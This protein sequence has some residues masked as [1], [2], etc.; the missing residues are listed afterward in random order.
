[1]V[2]KK[3]SL[4]GIFF[5]LIF[6]M[7]INFNI[8]FSD[9]VRP[10]ETLPVTAYTYFLTDEFTDCGPQ[11]SKVIKYCDEYYFRKKVVIQGGRIIIDVQDEVCGKDNRCEE[12]KPCSINNPND[13][14][15]WQTKSLS[16]GWYCPKG[17]ALAKMHKPGV[18]DPNFKTVSISKMPPYYEKDFVD[19]YFNAYIPA[20]VNRIPMLRFKAELIKSEKVKKNIT[21]KA[22]SKYGF[23]DKTITKEFIENKVKSEK[24]GLYAKHETLSYD[25]N[26][27]GGLLENF[28]LSNQKNFREVYTLD[29]EL[30]SYRMWSFRERFVDGLKRVV[31]S[32]NLKFPSGT[33]NP[34]LLD[35]SS[36]HDFNKVYFSKDFMLGGYKVKNIDSVPVGEEFEQK[37]N[38]KC[39]LDVNDLGLSYIKNNKDLENALK[40]SYKKSQVISK[41]NT[42]KSICDID[43][44]STLIDIEYSGDLKGTDNTYINKTFILDL[45]SI[46]DSNFEFSNEFKDWASKSSNYDLLT[47]ILRKEKILSEENPTES[48]NDIY[49]INLLESNLDLNI[50]VK[51]LKIPGISNSSD[52]KNYILS[53]SNYK[54]FSKLL[55]DEGYLSKAQLIKDINSIMI[56]DEDKLSLNVN[57]L[58]SKVEVNS[59][60]LLA[61]DYD[62]LASVN[63]KLKYKSSTESS[64]NWRSLQDLTLDEL[65]RCLYNWD[66]CLFNEKFEPGVSWGLNEIADLG[67]G[68]RMDSL[69]YVWTKQRLEKEFGFSYGYHFDGA[70]G[71][72][73]I[74]TN[75][76]VY[77]KCEKGDSWISEDQIYNCFDGSIYKCFYGLSSDEILFNLIKGVANVG[78]TI[79]YKNGTGYVCLKNKDKG[80]IWAK[81]DCNVI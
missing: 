53:L 77:K 65:G 39:N 9:P 5:G 25:A 34:D 11:N 16:N 22:Y 44:K 62:G 63:I 15:K 17:Y 49:E 57:I 7:L 32:K 29:T 52:L 35:K 38:S 78:D 51:D 74:K 80:Y 47:T 3:K 43:S 45:A 10:P 61:Q 41:L 60:I 64:W 27:M 1:M 79:N 71:K 14:N 18:L 40:N 20:C 58:L 48:I 70:R 26:P 28:N 37:L 30:D 8:S 21:Y 59:K 42:K 31:S 12:G 73:T 19:I 24:I 6:I 33:T 76:T 56:I 66:S 67:Y 23:E 36:A 55:I 4:I 68:P 50:N 75:M 72:N 13:N 81:V 2:F 54:M 46:S 69:A